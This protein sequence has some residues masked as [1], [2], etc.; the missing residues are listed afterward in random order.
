MTT[1]TRHNAI[2]MMM[3]IGGLATA[4]PTLAQAGQSC[5]PAASKCSGAKKCGAKSMKARMAAMLHGGK[6]GANKCAPKCGAKCAPAKCGPAKCA[7][8]CGA[9]CAP[10]T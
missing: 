1:K 6:C 2:A 4:A 10:R 3:V 5:Q 9:K 7:P 8:K